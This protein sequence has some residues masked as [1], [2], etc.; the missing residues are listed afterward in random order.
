GGAMAAKSNGD[1]SSAAAGA[2][3]LLCVDEGMKAGTEGTVGAAAPGGVNDPKSKGAAGALGYGGG[4]AAPVPKSGLRDA[5]TPSAKTPGRVTSA[6]GGSFAA[7]NR[8]NGSAAGAGG[9]ATA[10]CWLVAGC[11]ISRVTRKV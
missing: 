8:A 2:L 9:G 5:S 3:P 6:P 10:G 4:L 11:A 1:E 7:P